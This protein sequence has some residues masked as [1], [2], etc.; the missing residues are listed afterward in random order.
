[1]IYIFSN[2]LKNRYKVLGLMSGT[3][4]DGLDIVECDFSWAD[5]WKFQII[6][7][8]T[9]PYPKEWKNKLSRLSILEDQDLNQLDKEYTEYLSVAVAKFIKDNSISG[10][11]FVSSHGH[12]AKHRPNEGLTLQIGNLPEIAERLGITVVCDFR[13]QDVKLGG[14][15]APLVPIGDA[16]LFGE[17]DYCLNLGGFSNISFDKNGKRVAFDIGPVNTVLNYYVQQ[18]ELAF[19]N[20]GLIASGGQINEELL[21]NLNQLSYYK[22]PLPKSLGIEWV[23]EQV[24]PMI[25]AYTL[26]IAD[27]LRTMVE[28]ISIKI[29]KEVKANSSVL[30][31]GGGAY[32]H[33][34]VERIK[35]NSKARF[36]IPNKQLIEYKEALIFA[37]L[38]ILKIRGEHNCLSSVT[39]ASRDHSSGMVYYPKNS[40]YITLTPKSFLYLL[41]PQKSIDCNI[42]FSLDYLIETA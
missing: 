9:I 21:E 29:G 14:Q 11:D 41:L 36:I 19:D 31:T 35:A 27:V 42:R 16:L 34:L 4:L 28:H 8:K 7:A 2:M 3:S 17:Y 33:F 20:G 23:N 38:G 32:N 12:T 25:D 5:A 24:I 26:K 15:G 13:K 6:K 10:L 22:L 1:M 39:G 37:L 30:V 18:L 40:N